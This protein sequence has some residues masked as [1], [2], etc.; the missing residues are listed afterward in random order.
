MPADIH[1]AAIA[2]LLTRGNVTR[3]PSSAPLA[4]FLGEGSPSKIDYRKQG[5][6][7]PA[8]LITGSPR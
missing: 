1:V 6:L 7:I 2:A 8:S 5:A 4:N 3:S